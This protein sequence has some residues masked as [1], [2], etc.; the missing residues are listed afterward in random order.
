MDTKTQSLPIAHTQPHSNSRP[1]SHTCSQCNCSHHCQNCGQS[2][3]QNQSGSRSRNSSQSPTS[4]R[5]PPGSCSPSGHQ[6]QSPSPS[7]PPKHH[8][9]TMHSH[10]APT[11]PTTHC[12]S[13]PRKR[14][15]LEGK[16]NKRKVGKRIQQ[17][18]KTK[19]RSTGRRYK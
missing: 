1:R 3:R 17:V 13:C 2:C 5:S 15:T 10:H 12:S 9:Q 14:K 8:K 16:V 6:S 19:R 7:P 11:R 4:R 18:Y